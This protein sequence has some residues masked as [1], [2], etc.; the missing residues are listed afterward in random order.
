MSEISL[1]V[2][3]ATYNEI[4][5]LPSLVQAIHHELPAAD[6]LV[7]DDNSPDGTGRWCEAYAQ[8]HCWFRCLHRKEKQGLGSAI[9]AAMREAIDQGH[10]IVLT[11]DADWS[12]PPTSL[13]A[14]A[15]ATRQADVVIGSRYLAGGAIEGWPL[16]RRWAS[17]GVNLLARHLAGLPVS[18]CSG[19]FRAYRTEA[20]QKLPWE[21]LRATGYSF[22]EEILWHLD[23]QGARFAEVP[24]LFTD[25]Q[26][27]KSKINFREVISAAGTLMGLAFRRVLSDRSRS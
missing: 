27:G 1:L 3:L 8:D 17:W 16:Y 21:E 11:L 13:P 23:R 14:L 20:L 2:A 6:L 5:T 24:I 18:D 12:H 9:T 26:Q 19:N 4:E 15:E 7:V 10:E 25:R 22:L